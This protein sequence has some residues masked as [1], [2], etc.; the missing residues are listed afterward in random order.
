MV[1]FS[2]SL[3]EEYKTEMASTYGVFVND[4]D[5][6]IQLKR[7]VRTMF[8]TTHALEPDASGSFS[9]LASARRE[10]GASITPTSGQLIN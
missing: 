5:A 9:S 6:Q 1:T 4:A 7:L 3:I 8:P 10:V 2:K